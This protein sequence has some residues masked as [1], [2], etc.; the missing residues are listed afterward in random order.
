MNARRLVGWNVRRLRLDRG[1]TQEALGLAAGCE[2]SYIGR[3]ERGGE[4]PTVDL[5]E[6][7]ASSFDTHISVLFEPVPTGA[8]WPAGLPAGRKRASP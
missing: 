6:A 7:I 4:N 5:L 1:L 2:P 3:I 8:E